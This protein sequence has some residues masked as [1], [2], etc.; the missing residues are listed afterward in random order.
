M[1]DKGSVGLGEGW[2]KM[3]RIEMKVMLE[4]QELLR[5]ERQATIELGK[6][7]A[8]PVKMAAAFEDQMV[9]L[10]T[11]GSFDEHKGGVQ[12]F[13]KT[14]LVMSRGIPI[15]AAGLAEIATQAA[16]AGVGAKDLKS[17]VQVSAQMASAFDIIP[18]QAGAA[19]QKLK[20]SFALPHDQMAG[21]G[22]TI[23]HLSRTG[24]V[25]GHAL[26]GMTAKLSDQAK[27]AGL[28]AKETAVLAQ[29]LLVLRKGP[30]AA[31]GGISALT[32]S[33]EGYDTT[34][35]GLDGNAAD[36][37][38]GKAFSARMNSTE[39]SLKLLQNQMV[40]I[41]VTLGNGLLKPM[42]WVIDNALIPLTSGVNTLM[43]QMPG[44]SAFIYSAGLAF[45]G[46]RLAMISVKMGTNF[47]KMGIADVRSVMGGMRKA[48]GLGRQALGSARGA[49]IAFGKSAV[50]AGAKSRAAQLG[51]V[52]GRWGASL[53]GMATRAVPVGITALRALSVAVMSN[54]IGLSVGG[55]ALAAGL[56]ISHWQPVKDFF[57]SIWDAV[58]P[59]W[60][61]FVKYIGEMW[62]TL[63]KPLKILSNVL[64]HIF[65]GK[66]KAKVTLD[67]ETP[68]D[69]EAISEPLPA[70]GSADQN[71][72]VTSQTSAASVPSQTVHNAI[73]ITVNGAPGQD[74]ETLADLVIRRIKEASE[75]ALFDVEGAV[76]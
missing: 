9:K 13:G 17:L 39:K 70:A 21:L 67:V 31:K 48:V 11:V 60:D 73:Q 8:T 12:A 18:A 3:P 2:D 10:G 23:A 51:G 35:A 7:M 43:N 57:G 34:L 5:Q 68:P 26:L 71:S 37:A 63:S 55:I 61:S 6:T 62:E 56:L 28:S 54:P 46:L 42:K 16:S 41:G 14:L 22:D 58:K 29:R 69:L 76:T 52:F 15:S 19:M 38:L 20:Q 74:I 36:G 33:L 66:K 30:E 50:V 45:V 32:Q 40:E 53:M 27:T 47:V 49:M 75:G 59:A 72:M 4:R 24:G 1:T 44:L 25:S 64:G 65:G